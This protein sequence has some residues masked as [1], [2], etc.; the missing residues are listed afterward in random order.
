VERRLRN[1]LNWVA[2][3]ALVYFLVF[4]FFA[5]AF[6]NLVDFVGNALVGG[7]HWVQMNLQLTFYG[8]LL[9]CAF[10]YVVWKDVVLLPPRYKVEDE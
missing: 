9:W 3:T 6:G 8:Y 5:I 2:F 4:L 10:Q 1:L 7:E